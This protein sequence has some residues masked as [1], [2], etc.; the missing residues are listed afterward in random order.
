MSKCASCHQVLKNA[1]GPALVGF[2][3]RG[4]WV[5]RKKVYEWIKNPTAFMVKDKY[6]QELKKAYGSMMTRFPDLTNEEIDA[7][8]EYLKDTNKQK[9]APIAFN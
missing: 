7:I 9:N 8:I 2:E 3:E 4:P 1:T 6:T 5:D